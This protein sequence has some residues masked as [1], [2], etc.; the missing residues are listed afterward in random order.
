M[1]YRPFTLGAFI[2]CVGAGKGTGTPCE[3]SIGRHSSGTDS[4][5]T[6]LLRYR[7]T[8]ASKPCC[9]LHHST[10]QTLSLGKPQSVKLSKRLMNRRASDGETK[11]TRA[12]PK[13]LLHLKSTGRYTKL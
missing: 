13:F 8:C 5:I 11:L 7:S 9:G 2:F 6:G 4:C 1:S 12:Y 10:L 3:K